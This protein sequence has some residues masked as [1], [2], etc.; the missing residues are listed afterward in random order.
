MWAYIEVGSF[1]ELGVGASA[2]LVALATGRWKRRSDL[3]DF[4][5]NAAGRIGGS[6]NQRAEGICE[7]LFGEKGGEEKLQSLCE[8]STRQ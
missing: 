6:I 1:V 7:E 3:V 8:Q 4:E 5:Y 2:K